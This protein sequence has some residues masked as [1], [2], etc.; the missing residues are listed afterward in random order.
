[1][2]RLYINDKEVILSEPFESTA[3]NFKL[4]DSESEKSIRSVISSI[5]AVDEHHFIILTNNPQ[6]TLGLIKNIYTVIP[7]AGGIVTNNAD[8]LLMILRNGKWDLP[9]GKMEKGESAEDS[10]LREVTEE[11]GLFEL[12]IIAEASSTYHTYYLKGQPILKWTRWYHMLSADKK[13]P[14]PQKEEGIEKCEWMNDPDIKEAM[15]KTYLS[16]KNL[17]L[18]EKKFSDQE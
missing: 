17:L 6:K 1:M 5:E 11:C 4:N 2:L 13:L 10:A 18:D 8:Q 14:I 7:A 12:S 9:K 15:K 3:F 16:I